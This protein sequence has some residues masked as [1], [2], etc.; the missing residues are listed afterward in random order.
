MWHDRDIGTELAR[1]VQ[2]LAEPYGVETRIAIS[3]D[4]GQIPNDIIDVASQ[5]VRE[6]T[7]NALRH[8]ESP[9]VEVAAESG[10]GF[11]ILTITDQ[12]KGFDP[13]SV[14]SGLGLSSLRSRAEKAGGDTTL[15]TRVGR[16]T[17]VRVLL[18]I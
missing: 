16:G 4:L 5:I 17:T 11:L 8:S 6:A 18:P 10:A 2:Q 1:L 14:E 9:T 13:A 12:G 3:P 7:S 15:Q